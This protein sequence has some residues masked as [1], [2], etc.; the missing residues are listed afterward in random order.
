MSCYTAPWIT[1]SQGGSTMHNQKP[2]L[3]LADNERQELLAISRSRTESA[4]RVQRAT[5]LLLY[6]SGTGIMAI[7]R[8]LAT[9][10]P[11]VYRAIDKALAFGALASLNDIQRSGRS[12]VID[13]AAKNWVIFIACQRP[14]ELGY[15]AET[16]TY[17]RLVNH[18][19]THAD[20]NGHQCLSKVS[21]SKVHDILTEG[22]VRPHK[23]RYYLERRDARFEEKMIDVLCVYKDVEMINQSLETAGKRES[24]TVSYDEKPGIQAIKNIAAQLRPVPGEHPAIGRDYEYKRLGTVSLLGGIDLHTGVVHALVKDRHRSR[25]F[26]EFLDMI[27]GRYPEDWIIRIILD[28]HSAHVSKETQLYLKSRPNRFH[29][30]FTPKHGSWLNLVE[31]FFSK[32]ARS[33]LR[34]IRVDSKQELVERIYQGIEEINQ[35]PVLFRWRYKMEEIATA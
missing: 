28:N 16:W 32:I 35:A 11:L 26:I 15:A 33:F 10:R 12:R 18:V 30:V 20:R 17:S 7:T 27:D 22:A 2:N 25:E 13:D 21:R 14:T 34:H 8:Q 24:T 23:I 31:S 5:I 29:F 4:S 3:V 6:A 1:I 19:R 9:T